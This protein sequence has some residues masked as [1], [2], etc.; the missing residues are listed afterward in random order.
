MPDFQK[1]ETMGESSVYSVFYWKD[2]NGI[3]QIN[4]LDCSKSIVA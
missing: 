1:V 2:L 3:D 4:E